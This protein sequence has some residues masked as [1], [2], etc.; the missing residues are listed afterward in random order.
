MDWGVRAENPPGSYRFMERSLPMSDSIIACPCR[1]PSLRRG[2]W[3]RLFL[4]CSCSPGPQDGGVGAPIL[5]G[6]QPSLRALPA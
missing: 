2:A 5:V 3:S 1:F 6:R 4:P